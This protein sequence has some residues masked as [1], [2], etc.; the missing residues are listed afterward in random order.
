[1]EKYLLNYRTKAGKNDLTKK[2]SL[3]HQSNKKK[4]SKRR[5]NIEI[6]LFCNLPNI[7]NNNKIIYIHPKKK[8]KEITDEN[9]PII[10][11]IRNFKIIEREKKK[12]DIHLYLNVM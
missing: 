2:I 11:Y 12:L 6:I 5:R 4:K 3:I 9:I 8:K 10:I 1:M 7:K